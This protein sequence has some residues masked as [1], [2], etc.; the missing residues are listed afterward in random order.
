MCVGEAGE[1]CIF[2]EMMCWLVISSSNLLFRMTLYPDQNFH[3][4]NVEGISQGNT[5]LLKNCKP[6]D[7]QHSLSNV[8]KKLIFRWGKL[9][10]IQQLGG[11]VQN[12]I[13]FVFGGYITRHCEH[14]L[15]FYTKMNAAFVG[16][17]RL[18]WFWNYSS[19]N[20]ILSR[21]VI[22]VKSI[23][24]SKIYVR[25]GSCWVIYSTGALCWRWTD[26][27]YTSRSFFP[28]ER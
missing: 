13:Y 8:D 18:M 9:D 5:E 23:A 10:Q 24:C 12:C 1:I 4:L 16:G 28:L 14:I 3:W 2:I 7:F 20:C 17:Y 21:E 26:T 11:G 6:T 27:I 22:G 19:T 25:S 15:F